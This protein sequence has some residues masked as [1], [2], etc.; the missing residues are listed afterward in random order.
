VSA[1]AAVTL[2]SFEEV[3]EAFRAKDLKQA[4][5]D[6]GG[7]VMA[8][9]LLT[10]HGDDHRLR[11]RLENRLFRRDTFRRYERDLTAEIVTKTLEPFLAAREGDLV[12][13][14]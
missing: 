6:E 1:P 2:R 5:Y 11:R 14:G 8:G 10:L 3:R 9:V 7:V 12:S 4:L 13:L